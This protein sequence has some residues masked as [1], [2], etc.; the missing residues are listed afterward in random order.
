VVIEAGC[1]NIRVAIA[2]EITKGYGAWVVANSVGARRTE[3]AITVV[4]QHRHRGGARDAGD[5][6]RMAVAVDVADG[7]RNR[8]SRDAGA[9]SYCRGKGAIAIVEQHGDCGHPLTWDDDI[10]VAIAVEITDGYAQ[11]IGS[12]GV[13]DSR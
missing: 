13:G 7:N 1:D 3:G 10:Q 2:V 9:I 11:G 6:I 5:D 12:S 8:I 4:E